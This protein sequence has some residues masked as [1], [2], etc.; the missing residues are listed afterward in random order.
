MSVHDPILLVFASCLIVGAFL[1]QRMYQKKDGRP[2]ERLLLTRICIF[3]VG[4]LTL[5]LW[6]TLPGKEEGVVNFLR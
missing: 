2:I 6:H 5:V 1:P 3:A 4:I